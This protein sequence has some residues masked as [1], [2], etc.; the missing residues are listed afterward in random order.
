MQETEERATPRRCRQMV[1]RSIPAS[2]PRDIAVLFAAAALIYLVQAR[3]WP[4]QPGRDFLRFLNYY[5]EMW[6]GNPVNHML[7]AYRTPIV[8]LYVGLVNAVGGPI[9][10]EVTQGVLFCLSVV[11]TFAIGCHWDRRIGYV[12]AAALAFYPPYGG[13][14]HRVD[15]AAVFACA[16]LGWVTFVFA[17]YRSSKIEIYFWHGVAVFLLILVRP[18]SQVLLAFSVVPLVSSHLPIRR[19]LVCAGVFLATTMAFTLLWSTHNYVRY[20]SFAVSRGR[21]AILPF[22]RLFV[23]NAA[24]QP[25]NGPASQ[26]LAEAV[27]E[28]LLVKEP[29]RSLQVDET[30]FY[31]SKDAKAFGDL[32]A[33]SDRWWG[34][35]TNYRHLRLVAMEA[36]TKSTKSRDIYVKSIAH[37]LL[38]VFL[39]NEPILPAV[40]RQQFAGDN[41][42]RL[43]DQLNEVGVPAAPPGRKKTIPYSYMHWISSSPA[44]T[45][46]P[47]ERLT[48][49]RKEIRALGLDVPPRDGDP[50]AAAA[51]ANLAKAYPPMITWILVGLL[52]AVFRPHSGRRVLL[53]LLSLSLLIV[54]LSTVCFGVK[55]QYRAPFDPLFILVGVAGVLY[56]KPRDS[57]A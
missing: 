48:R 34:W 31:S 16:F 28:D 51:L 52:G 10:L 23:L 14:Y 25:G 22:Y 46:I 45:P 50:K 8:P 47:P 29:Y 9:L 21:N 49:L 33:L 15:S 36:L 41:Y 1:I 35:E 55:C 13:L 20:D 18:S 6:R 42:G 11:F 53:V 56:S 26:E 30:A 7:M 19:R 57:Q 2:I 32:M 43:R 37:D 40:T 24:I 44:G 5:V 54:F 38:Q 4:L 39:R 27:R 3:A 17:T 12:G